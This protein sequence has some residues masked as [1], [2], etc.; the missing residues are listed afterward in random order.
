M[1]LEKFIKTI[2]LTSSDKDGEVLNAIKICNKIL[3]EENKTWEEIFNY[4]KFIELEDENKMLKE[5]IQKSEENTD[6]IIQYILNK[7]EKNYEQI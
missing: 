4:N 5:K 2:A 3:K 1:D 7:W 6:E